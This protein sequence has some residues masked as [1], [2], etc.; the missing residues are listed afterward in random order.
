M[1]TKPGHQPRP[2]TAFFDTKVDEIAFMAL[3]Q[4]NLFAELGGPVPQGMPRLRDDDGRHTRKMAFTADEMRHQFAIETLDKAGA[5]RPQPYLY[6]CVRCKWIFRINDS[7]GS[8]IAL[9]GLGRRLA[10]PEN[11]KRITTFHRG[12][13]PAFRVIEYLSR[14]VDADPRPDDRFQGYLARFVNA[15]RS[16]AGGGPRGS[17]NA[18]HQA[19]PP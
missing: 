6:R 12:P 11:A 15:L 19:T 2:L 10:E 8:I 17:T 4:M 14:E 18:R 5:L 9:D 13:C 3:R 1:K 7:R 16:L